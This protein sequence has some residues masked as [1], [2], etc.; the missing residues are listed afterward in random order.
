MTR[1]M[2]KIER[3]RIA[4]RVDGLDEIVQQLGKAQSD[5]DHLLSK[6]DGAVQQILEAAERLTQSRQRA[7]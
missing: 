1:V 6:M 2:C 5:L 7:A 4:E 3:S